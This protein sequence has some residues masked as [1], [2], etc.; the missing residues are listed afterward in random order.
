MQMNDLENEDVDRGINVRFK[1]LPA[2]R[3]QELGTIS[4]LNTLRCGGKNTYHI[5]WENNY[6]ILAQV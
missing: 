6:L 1:G 5:L 2:E 4:T 3:T